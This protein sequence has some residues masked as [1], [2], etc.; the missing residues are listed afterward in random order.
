MTTALTLDIKTTKNLFV[1]FSSNRATMLRGRHGIGKSQ[2]VYQ[3]ASE[4][5]HDVYKNQVV[6]ERVSA[7]LA[8]DSGFVKM[9]AS[10][11][12]KN[13]NNP[14]YAEVPR[15][16]W[17]YDMG[18]PVV[19]RR[20]SQMTEG[21]ITG[22]PFEGNRG[23]TVFRA[24]EWLLAT[25]EF[26]CVLFLDELN[27]AIK[28]V[29]QATFQLADSKAFDGNL[30]HDGTRVMVAINIGDQY[31]VTPMDPAAL[32]RYAVVDLDPTTQDW[33]DWA[34]NNCHEGLVEFIRSNERLLEFKGTSEPNHKTPD[35]R[36]WGNLDAEL[37]Q[38]GL[39]EQC[40]DPVFY[41]MTASM[42]GTEAAAKFWNFMKERAL[43]ISANDVL[44]DWDA[45]NERLPKD[46]AKRNS[47][48]VDIM[49]KVNHKLKDHLMTDQERV[50]YVKFFKAAPAEVRFTAWKALGQNITNLTSIHPMIRGYLS[51]VTTVAEK[52]AA[53]T[54]KK[55][56]EN[57]E[58]SNKT[59]KTPKP[60]SRK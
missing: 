13:G 35:R 39:Y 4:L 11:W 27:R 19:E 5:R 53:E 28:G 57:V 9:V 10:F 55:A 54:Q 42:V 15:T 8:K 48:F 33:L 25:C 29:E 20:L 46:V 31:D 41:H 38:S 60:R 2:V 59:A 58:A 47:K 40:N 24:C 51:E 30:L 14:V 17:H 52:S 6:C 12:K 37:T 56:E 16:Q 32:S 43:D 23:G 7:A 36:A 3:I 34:S 22:I 45:C 18:V 49:G 50:E 44:K 21:D 26:P 1:R